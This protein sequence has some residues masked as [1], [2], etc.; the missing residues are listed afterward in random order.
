M[1][2]IYKYILRLDDYQEVVMPAGARILSAQLQYGSI[3]IWAMVDVNREQSRRAF[4]IFGTGHDATDAEN[5]PH[6]GT[7]Q[8]S[9]FVWHIFDAGEQ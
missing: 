2:R 5:M 9:S 4:R 8:D 7:V 3:T 1:M 6:V